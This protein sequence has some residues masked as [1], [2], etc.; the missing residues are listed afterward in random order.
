MTFQSEHIGLYFGQAE[1]EQ[2]RNRRDADANL[3]MAWQWLR[4]KSGDVIREIKPDKRDVE[5]TII[6]KPSLSSLDEAVANG[7]HYRFMEGAQAG[8][9]AADSLRSSLQDKPTL[10]ETVMAT[11]AA[12][13]IY[14]MVRP[15]AAKEWLRQFAAYVDSLL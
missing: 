3:Q 11:V 15:L 9:Q 10:L 8:I 2:A 4:A 6:R 7:M 14:E 13:H 1:I 5:P 12:A